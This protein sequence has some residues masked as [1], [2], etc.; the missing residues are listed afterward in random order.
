MPDIKKTPVELTAVSISAVSHRKFSY[1]G[2]EFEAPWDDLDEQKTK[3]AGKIVVIAFH[4]G[5]AMWFSSFPPR[6]FVKGFLSSTSDPAPLRQIYGDE[7]FQSDYA[8]TR[9]MLEATPGRIT[10]FTPRKEA[11]GGMMLLVIK[12]ISMPNAASGLYSIRTKDFQGFQYGS[13]QG[14]PFKINDDLF[15]EDGGIEFIFYQKNTGPAPSISQAEI[16]RVIQ[17]IR[18]L[19]GQAVTSNA[20]PHE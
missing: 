17:S 9:A 6:E 11:I 20:N 5:N 3:L 15:A 19:P 1:F 10:P 8:F 14:R 18:K 7:V 4:S 2:Y 13:P 16:N 12:G